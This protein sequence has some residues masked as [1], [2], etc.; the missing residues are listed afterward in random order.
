MTQMDESLDC[1]KTVCDCEH[2]CNTLLK[3]EVNGESFERTVCFSLFN[4]YCLI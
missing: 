4:F 1:R 2:T 3:V